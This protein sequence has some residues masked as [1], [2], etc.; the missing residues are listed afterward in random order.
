MYNKYIIGERERERW[1]E[2]ACIRMWHERTKIQSR[3]VLHASCR[4]GSNRIQIAGILIMNNN[5]CMR[6]LSI[7]LDHVRTSKTR[8]HENKRR[9]WNVQDHASSVYA[10]WETKHACMCSL[11][12][13]WSWL[14]LFGM[15]ARSWSW[16]RS[17]SG[18]PASHPHL[19]ATS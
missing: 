15:A 9:R 1:G 8:G 2:V 19:A 10:C 14:A 13:S 12:A 3:T 18:R 16:S 7:N 11:E 6:W 17:R 4:S 5:A